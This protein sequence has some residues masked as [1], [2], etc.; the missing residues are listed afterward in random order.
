[1]TARRFSPELIA[2]LRESLKRTEDKGT[3]ERNDSAAHRL[4]ADACL[5][6]AADQDAQAAQYRELLRVADPKNAAAYADPKDAPDAQEWAERQA[7]I[8]GT[9]E[10]LDFL[11]AHPELPTSGFISFH[12]YSHETDS[13]QEE[14][15][16]NRFARLM[17]V[18]AGREAPNR[19]Y[20]AVRR[21][22][23]DGAVKLVAVATSR[24]DL[25]WKNGD[26][27]PD[28]WPT[29]EGVAAATQF[30]VESASAHEACDPV[31]ADLADTIALGEAMLAERRAEMTPVDPPGELPDECLDDPFA[32]GVPDGLCGARAVDLDAN[33]G[34][35]TRPE[36]HWNPQSVGYDP[37]HAQHHDP[38]FG[39]W[40]EPKSANTES[41]VHP[42]RD[43]ELSSGRNA[44]GDGE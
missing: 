28:W 8:I 38:G 25:K 34:R 23:P 3:E 14:M 5:R 18:P 39:A 30:A 32:D 43:T 27:F 16:V 19:H 7:R 44:D 2:G 12:I 24:T 37:Q 29:E 41:E 21:F 4:E 6:R 9:R 17:G 1:M 20:E 26:A 35:C 10:L 15:Q 31:A 42:G 11:E 36:G 33:T 22:G 40:D 13:V